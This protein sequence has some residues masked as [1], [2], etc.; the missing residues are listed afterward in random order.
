M[1]SAGFKR[2]AKKIDM[3]TILFRTSLVGMLTASAFYAQSLSSL[4]RAHVQISTPAP[5]CPP[6]IGDGP[7]QG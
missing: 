3:K 5:K 6:P 2:K 7:R 4:D 1:T